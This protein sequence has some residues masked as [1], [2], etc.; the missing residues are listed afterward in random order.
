MT[1]PTSAEPDRDGVVDVLHGVAVA[2]PFRWLE[3]ATSADTAAWTAAQNRRT[4][5]VLDALPGRAGLHARIRTLLGADTVTGVSIAGERLFCLQRT[6]ARDQ[7]QLVVHDPDDRGCQAGRV[8][9]DPVT[10]L[11]ND[12]AAIDWFGP[13][14][15][16]ALVAVG[17][18]C[19]G[20]ERS[21]L[22]V[23]DASTG[24]WLAERI[25]RTRAASLTW[26]PDGSAFAYTRYP[27]PATVPPGDEE[28]WR[29]VWWHVLADPVDNDELVFSHPADKTAWPNVSLSRDGR[30]LLVHLT[31]GCNRT[32][33]YLTD[34]H[35]GRRR[36]VVAGVDGVSYFQVVDDELIGVTTLDAPRG[37]VVRARCA[38]PTPERWDTVVAE[39]AS[40]IEAVVATAGSLLVSRTRTAVAALDRYDRH[41]LRRPPQAVRLPELGSLVCLSGS[42]ERDEA[43]FSFTSFVRPPQLFRW[44]S[45]KGAEPWSR[46]PEA[47]DPDRYTVTQERYR[48][49]DGIS[50]PIFLLAARDAVAG[51]A[52]AT[53]LNGYGGFG[54]TSRPAWSPAAVAHAD[55]G[56]V[57]VV[58]GIRGGSEEGEDWHRAG[59]RADKQQVFDDFAA[60][61]DWL[62]AQRRT[63]RSRLAITGDSNGGLLVT[64]VLTQRPDLCRAA[65]AAVPLTDML[66]YHR[67]GVGRLWVSE[68]GDPDVADEFAWLH[69]YSPYHRVADGVCY[70][71]VLVTTASGDSRVDP[72]HARKFTAR[73]QAGTT[74]GAHHPVL[75]RVE[76][77]AGH[78]QGKPAGRQADELSD[79]LSFLH[80]QLDV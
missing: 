38:A 37:R 49:N 20:D 51:P 18:S 47:V 3:D 58:A 70:P 46:Q 6:R 23:V 69:A 56:G 66:R 53:V 44:T 50:V 80:W 55:S 78:G 21:E 59:Q 72:A 41:D 40:I 52:T 34:R 39:S 36:T 28:Y 8:L 30:W 11:Q 35:S 7:A 63:S 1:R 5:E 33:V 42:H 62:V 67:F 15:D 43:W 61:A 26:M 64:A 24:V 13:S 45:A 19:G 17:L 76:D 48:S 10:E 54:V 22:R 73:L 2:D 25:S 77:G 79:W 75:L 32:D 74:C 68:L 31:M 65:H 4:R 16:G 60:A 29:S 27:D 71:A 12:T 57:W 9:V 14:P